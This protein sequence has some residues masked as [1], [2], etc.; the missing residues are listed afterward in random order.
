MS[1]KPIAYIKPN[2]SVFIAGRTGSG[3]SFL[4]QKYLT[5][6]PA[7]IALDSKV[8]IHAPTRGATDVPVIQVYWY[9]TL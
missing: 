1:A 4:A 7:V 3:K 9:I 5:N 6:Y 2:E 8:S